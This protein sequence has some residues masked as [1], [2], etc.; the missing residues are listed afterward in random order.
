MRCKT[1]TIFIDKGVPMSIHEGYY[2]PKYAP[3]GLKDPEGRKWPGIPKDK[4][5]EIKYTQCRDNSTTAVITII[6]ACP[7]TYIGGRQQKVCCGPID[8]FDLSFWAFNKL[9][10]PLYGLMMLDYR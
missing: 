2:L 7:C 6:D 3:K 1:G 10:H 4:D 8:H 5:Q 9:A